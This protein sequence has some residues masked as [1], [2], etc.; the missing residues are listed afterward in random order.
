MTKCMKQEGLCTPVITTRQVSAQPGS[1]PEVQRGCFWKWEVKVGPPGNI[2]LQVPEFKL[3]ELDVC[4]VT[5]LEDS[6][7]KFPGL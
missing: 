1:F 7:S 3:T 4:F 2:W 5:W 6:A